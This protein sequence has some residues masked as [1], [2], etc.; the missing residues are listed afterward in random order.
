MSIIKYAA[1]IALA[2]LPF[3]TSAEAATLEVISGPDATRQ[4][5][6]SA[7]DPVGQSFTAFTDTITSVGFQFGTLNAGAANSDITLNIY[8]GESLTGASLF[9]TVFT[10]P[11]SI[12]ARGDLAWI[13]FAVPDL[14]IT[15]GAQYSVVF[16][17]SSARA[18]L[19]TGPDYSVSTGEFGG[20]DAYEGGQLLTDASFIYA[21]CQ[22]ATNNCDTNF[23]I[24]GDITAVPE[25]A[26]WTMMILGLGLAGVSLRRRTV[27]FANA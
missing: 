16:T 10:L 21:N 13:D 19:V 14:Q 2:T 20:G 22:G 7:F 5:T 3:L 18:A 11:D 25:P 23:R 1:S 12:Q 6:V 15:N 27:T 4:I 8:A 24:T 9:S 17:A 26:S